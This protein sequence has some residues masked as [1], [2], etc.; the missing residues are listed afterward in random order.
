MEKYDVFN[1]LKKELL[2]WGISENKITEDAD[3]VK[4]L[5]FDE[6]DQ[7]QLVDN[8]EREYGICLPDN[9]LEHFVTLGDIVTALYDAIQARN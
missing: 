4:V 8:F 9:V 1:E 6:L 3:L 5:N 7:I 2:D